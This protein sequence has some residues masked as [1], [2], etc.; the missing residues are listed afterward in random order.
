MTQSF[1]RNMVSQFIALAGARALGAVFVFLVSLLITRFFGTEVMAHYSLYLAAASIISV[2]L[3]VGFH[4]IASMITAEYGAQARYRDRAAFIHY[5]HRL[6]ALMALGLTIIAGVFVYF[7][8]E[9]STYNLTTITAFT[10]PTAVFMAYTYFNAGTLIGMQHQF[11]GQLPDMAV[12]PLLLLIGIAGL[13]YFNMDVTDTHVLVVSSVA[14]GTAAFIQW[15]ALRRAL[16]REAMTISSSSDSGE[17]AKWWRLAPSWVVINVLWEYF[18]EVHMLI[19]GLLV[20]PSEVALLYVCF[21][22]RQLASFGFMA[23]ESLVFPKVFAANSK[24][25]IAETRNLVRV[26]ARTSLAYAVLAML[27]VAIL[28]PYIL[29]IFGPEF[30]SGQTILMLLFATLVVRA[31]FGPASIVLG[32]NRHSVLVAQILAISLIVSL[33]LC[34]GGFKFGGL[35]MIAVGYLAASIFTSV[36]MW[37]VALKKS[38]INCAVWA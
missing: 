17:P 29:S 7:S 28:G 24:G 9:D 38:G 16:A 23:I 14:V 33:V 12:R 11:A 21:R 26:V 36:A 25:E 13:A 34:F 35:T 4:A 10:I 8:P 3:P 15:W 1:I 20:A 22:F 2:I 37:W 6:I 30:R 31:I 19:A 5:G 27:G 32:M 18:V